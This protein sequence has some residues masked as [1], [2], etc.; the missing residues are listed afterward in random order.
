[1]SA[2]MPAAPRIHI[3]RRN[4]TPMR[5]SS[6]STY[7]SALSSTRG[8]ARS[9][10]ACADAVR[11]I[12]LEDRTNL[13]QV[14]PLALQVVDHHRLRRVVGGWILQPM[15]RDRR[16][17]CVVIGLVAR[18]KRALGRCALLIAE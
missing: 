9:F 10:I 11:R 6:A 16:V 14:P 12:G 17:A 2:A 1:M 7:S 15:Q 18:I 5:R 13:G 3:E 8:G 4:A